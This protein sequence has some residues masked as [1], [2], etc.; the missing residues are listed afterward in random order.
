MDLT[1]IIPVCDDLRIERCIKS[2][3]EDVEI[4]EKH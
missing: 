3:D 4:I 2:I 1:I